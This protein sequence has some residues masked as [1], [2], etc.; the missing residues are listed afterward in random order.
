V[1]EEPPPHEKRAH[2]SSKL[3]PVVIGYIRI[4]LIF[5]SGP[6]MKTARTVAL[7]AGVRVFA[8]PETDAGSM[9][10]SLAAL[11]SESPIAFGR[12]ELDHRR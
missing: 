4:S 10:Y 7:S 2:T 8:S 6:M 12:A 1:A 11:K 5:L 9:S 3:R